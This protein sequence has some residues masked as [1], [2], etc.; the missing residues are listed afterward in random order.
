M[1][2]GL[3]LGKSTKDKLNKG[4]PSLVKGEP[5]K[6]KFTDYQERKDQDEYVQSP[7]YYISPNGY[8]MTLTTYANGHG[9]GEGTHVS[10]CAEIHE[11]RYDAELKWPFVGKI[12]FTLLN[13]LE[14]K[15]HHQ[16]IL[17]V[18]SEDNA[19]VGDAWGFPNFIPHSELGYDAENT[20]PQGRH[21]VFQNV[22]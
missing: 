20:V 7:S 10:V 18:T 3:G 19:Q 15:N 5:I 11:G 9:F 8:H 14:N 6:F 17:N 21:S 13:Q 12:I 1:G 2:A 4:S 16:K 22:S